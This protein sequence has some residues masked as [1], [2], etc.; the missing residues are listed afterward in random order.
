MR[1]GRYGTFF[2]GHRAVGE[3]RNPR[4]GAKIAIAATRSPKVSAGKHLKG[5]VNG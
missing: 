4:T 2:V 3:G 5:A 1:R